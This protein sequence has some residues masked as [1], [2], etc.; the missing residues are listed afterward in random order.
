MK[1]RIVCY[2]DVNGWILGK[3][4]RRL[5]ENLIL[6]GVDATVANAPDSSA[7]INHHIIYCSYDGKKTTTETVMITHIDMD[8]KI[9]Q[10]R[11]QLVEAE[12]GICMSMDM[13]Q[14]LIR[15][16]IP[17][18]KLCYINPAHDEG[19]RPRKRL[20]GITSKV[21]ATGCKREDMLLD[22]ARQI[23]T[24]DF[25]FFVMGDDWDAIVDSMREL[26]FEV[27]YHDRF[28]PVIYGPAVSRFDFY[29]YF[30]QDEGSMGFLDALSAGVPTIVT[31]QGF[32]LD[33]VDGITHS[34]ND[35]SE[36]V[37]IFNDIAEQKNRLHRSVQGWT[38]AE[39]ARKHV[40]IWDY[41]LRQK[42]SQPV[43]I[44]LRAQLRSIN[45]DQ[46]RE[47]LSRLNARVFHVVNIISRIPRSLRRN[48]SYGLRNPRELLYKIRRRAGEI[49]PHSRTHN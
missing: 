42:N 34:F 4:A 21:Q 14:K 20:I 29:L 28:D 43:P 32:H 39:Y 44:S 2:E 13:Y 37:K 30:G 35:L 11:R 49:V 3:F 41:L 17:R 1:V 8:W 6:Q 22:L 9:D 25:K 46:E 16:G 45:V 12:M 5:Q 33:V 38:W 24:D 23:S 7:D 18:H 19:L 36:L 10:V 26:G 31:P 40:A 47:G 27:E 48:L 15:W